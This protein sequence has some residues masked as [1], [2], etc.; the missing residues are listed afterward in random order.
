V[1][2][3]N[4]QGGEETPALSPTEQASIEVGQRGLSEPTNDFTPAPTGPQR[5]DHIPEKFWKDG[6]VDVEAMAKSYSELEKSRSQAPAATEEKPAETPTAEVKA[7]GKIEKT[8]ETPTEAPAASPLATAMETARNE[9]AEKQE[10]SDETVKALED[11]GIPREVFNLYIEGVKAQTAQQLQTIH[12]YV[13]GEENYKAMAA[14][15]GQ[16]LSDK[17]LDAFNSALDNAD[18]RENA[19][20]GLYARFEKARPSEGSMI[21]PTGGQAAGGDVYTSRDQLTADQKDPRYA[22][23]PAFR[24]QVMQ[25][26]ARSQQSGFSVVKRGLFEKQVLSN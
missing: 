10:V 18:L 20:T 13:G 23:D 15:A 25:K 3:E 16:H 17:E 24:D 11:A 7:D 5:P 26:L 12:G 4:T 22:S 21:V 1:A 2:E 9:W 8:Q 6:K 14:W 19:I